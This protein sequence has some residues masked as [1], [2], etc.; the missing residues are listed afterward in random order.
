MRRK[1]GEEKTLRGETP[2]LDLN[3]PPTDESPYIESK[4]ISYF[5]SNL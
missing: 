5:L 1:E 4:I 3:E 2:L